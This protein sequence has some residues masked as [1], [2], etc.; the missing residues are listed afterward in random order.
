MS[1]DTPTPTKEI[2]DRHGRHHDLAVGLDAV[3]RIDTVFD[4]PRTDT[5]TPTFET[6][7]VI[8]REHD[9]VPPTVL[10]AVA[11]C[12]LGLGP[13]DPQGSGVQP[14]LYVTVQ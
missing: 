12:D 1:T 7:L 8:A 5:D 14:Q 11:E 6:E 13:V 10:E 9:V 2:A 3:D 4:G